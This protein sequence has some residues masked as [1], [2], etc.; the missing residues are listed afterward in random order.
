[1][2][3]IKLVKAYYGFTEKE[4]K[5]YIKGFTENGKQKLKEDI[6]KYFD[7]QAKKKFL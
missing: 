6:K 4:A 5:T 2:E 1:M 7:L 3:L